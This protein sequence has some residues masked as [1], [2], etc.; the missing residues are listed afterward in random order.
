MY[1]Q[2]SLHADGCFSLNCIYSIEHEHCDINPSPPF[3]NAQYAWMI[4]YSSCVNKRLANVD[5]SLTR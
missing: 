1:Q 2:L 3:N 4:I 5:L